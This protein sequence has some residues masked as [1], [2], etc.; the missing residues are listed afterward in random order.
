MST[1]RVFISYSNDSAEHS[2][3]VRSF[4]ARL[5]DSGVDAF[6]DVWDL[7]PGQDFTRWIESAVESSDFCIAVCSPRY[8]QVAESRR[9]DGVG[10]EQALIMDAVRQRAPNQPWVLP[11]LRSGAGREAIPDWLMDRVYV[12]FSDDEKFDENFGQVLAS[13]FSREKPK[14]PPSF[15]SDPD[16]KSGKKTTFTLKIEGAVEDFDSERLKRL[17]EELRS[18]LGDDVT[19][20][21]KSDG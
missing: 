18:Y 15:P 16:S 17:L 2:T 4:A 10:Y 14:H 7:R 9:R 12:D 13:L 1:P 11:I 3:W 19:I 5:R 6:L 21:E 8:R 20:S